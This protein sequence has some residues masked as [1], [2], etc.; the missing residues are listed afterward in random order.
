MTTSRTR[1]NRPILITTIMTFVLSLIASLL[2]TGPASAEPIV[3][4]AAT[5]TVTLQ[6]PTEPSATQPIATSEDQLTE[7]VPATPAAA[8]AP[9]VYTVQ[10]NDWLSTIAPRFNST[11]DTLVALNCIQDPDVIHVGTVLKLDG[12]PVCPEVAK[13]SKP[14][15]VAT[16]APNTSKAA[17]EPATTPKPDHT[18]AQ[19]DLAPASAS[20]VQKVIAFATAQIGKPYVWGATGPSSFDCSGLML[21]AFKQAGITLPRTAREQY[22]AGRKVSKSEILPGDQVFS[23][24]GGRPYGHVGVYIGNGRMIVAPSSGQLV[25]YASVDWNR[26]VGATRP[27]TASAAAQA[28]PA[29]AIQ[30][31]AYTAPVAKS[32]AAPASTNNMTHQQ[33]ALAAGIPSSDFKYVDSIVSRESGWNHLISNAQGSSAYGLCQA[34]PGS[35]MSSAGA[36]W[37][38][39]AVTQLRWC[40]SYAKSRYGSWSKAYNF[41][42]ANHWW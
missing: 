6:L 14:E 1:Q 21:A 2:V 4:D 41:W 26:F 34:L 8:P 3:D 38:T 5:T 37:K 13:V 16:P 39:N 30:A 27:I 24:Y 23:N 29:P 22:M 7:A 33:L 19:S 32:T 35:K 17:A 25:K 40:D 9:Q 20:A 28:A 18:H 12:L 10:P 31:A 42:N 15:H 11:V 36:D